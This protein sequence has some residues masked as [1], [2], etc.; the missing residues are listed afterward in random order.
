MVLLVP[1]H[2]GILIA[3][4]FEKVVPGDEASP[5]GACTAFYAMAS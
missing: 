4:G 3:A 2:G 5:E 1:G